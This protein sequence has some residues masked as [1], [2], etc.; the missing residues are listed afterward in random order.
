MGGMMPMMGQMGG[1][2]RMPMGYQDQMGGMGFQGRAMGGMGMNGPAGPSMGN[3]M[4]GPSGMTMGSGPSGPGQ[5]SMGGMGPGPSPGNMG[6]GVGRMPSMGMSAPGMNMGPTGGQSQTPMMGG[7][8]GNMMNMTDGVAGQEGGPGVHNPPPPPNTTPTPGQ[9][10]EVNTSTVCRIGQE[11]VEEIV[12]RTQEVFSI[13]K[14][15][16]PPVGSYSPQTVAHDKSNQEKQNRLQDVL[17][18]IGMLFKRLR[19]CWEKC[20]E[21]TGGM[22]FMPIESLIPLKEDGEGRVELEKKRGDAYK[23]AAEEHN[24]LVQQ[25]TLKNRHLKD[26]IDQMRNIIWEINT[27]LAIRKA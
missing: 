4:M 27:M 3:R 24:E 17:K 13:L 23:S 25:I 15:L 6:P 22:D 9:S 11:T 10:K 18:G 26:V 5:F 14:S 21:N 16:Q 19:V 8:T 12:S 7:E 2:N 20:Q 1:M